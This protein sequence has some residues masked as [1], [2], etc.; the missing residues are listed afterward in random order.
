[1]SSLAV[2]QARMGSSR[3][4]GKVAMEIGGRPALVLMLERIVGAADQTVVATSIEPAD[5]AVVALAASVGVPVVRGSE[6]D[7]LARF[8]HAAN[9]YPADTIVRLTADCP[10]A[11]P[12]LVREAI[13]THEAS[14]AAYTSNTLIR[15][16]PD[17]LDVEA[18][19]RDALEAAGREASNRVEREHVTPFIIRQPERFHLR[20]FR[21]DR[22][23]GDLRWTLDT[24]EDLKFLR[25]LADM[26]SD[27][28][29]AGWLELLSTASVLP[30]PPGKLRLTPA[31]AADSDLALALRNDPD[32]VNFSRTAKAVSPDD[33]ARWYS[34]HLVDPSTRI[35]TA[36]VDRT[37]VGQVRISVSHGVGVIGIGVVPRFRG[38]GYALAMLEYLEVVLQ[39]DL[40]VTR[41]LAEVHASNVASA[42][43]FVRAGYTPCVGDDEFTS[44]KRQIR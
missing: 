39:A 42:A 19:R 20:A 1:M 32:A 40:Q 41:L 13:A 9:E 14:G 43:T 23:L 2:V 21:T 3:L 5:D 36:R 7:V 12:A 35:W 31:V 16:Y 29:R 17:G 30:H 10:F 18:F 11:D 28:V 38:S 34:R 15:T 24:S 6:E 33:H 37:A 27:L 4:P 26:A 8:V 25:A 22:L 44:F